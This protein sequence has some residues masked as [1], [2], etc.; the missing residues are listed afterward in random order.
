MKANEFK[1]AVCETVF[2]KGLTEKEAVKQ[3]EEEFGKGWKPE[4][5]ES[6]CN[7]CYKKMFRKESK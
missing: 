6:V 1:C 5:C 3:L 2:K 7:D 4:D